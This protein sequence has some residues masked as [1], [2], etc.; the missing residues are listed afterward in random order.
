M[1]PVAAQA[2]YPDEGHRAALRGFEK[3][4]GLKNKRT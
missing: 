3:A 2:P 1:D 4:T